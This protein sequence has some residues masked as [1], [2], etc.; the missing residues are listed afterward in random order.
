MGVYGGKCL[1]DICH[2]TVSFEVYLIFIIIGV[3]NAEQSSLMQ[4]TDAK[5]YKKL[6]MYT[7]STWPAIV[8]ANEYLKKICSRRC[9]LFSLIQRSCFLKMTT[10]IYAI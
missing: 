3:P 6:M 5:L 7:M 9:L 2:G 8:G 10:L 4:F 1:R